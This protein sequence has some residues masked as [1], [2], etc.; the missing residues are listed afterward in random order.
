MFK[1]EDFEDYPILIPKIIKINK[2]IDKD[3]TGN[4]PKI[5]G[6]LGNL[7]E[8]QDLVVQI[9]YILSVIA[10]YDIDLITER[11]IQ[12]IEKFLLSDDDKLKINSIIIIGFYITSNPN[13][14]EK[15]YETF[16]NFIVDN[17]NDVRDNAH[18][19]LQEFIKEKPKLISRYS[20]IILQALEIEEKNK[21]N[22][23]SLLNFLNQCDSLNF[24]QLFK[25]RELSKR[26]ISYFYEGQKSQI[27]QNLIIILNKFFT[28]LKDLKLENL[29]ARELKKLLD[30]QF[31]MKKEAFTELKDRE[32]N[33]TLKDYIEK[34]RNSRLKGV[35][36][37][38]FINDKKNNE[39]YFYQLEKDK[40]I[41]VFDRNKKIPLN[42][43]KILFSEIINS[44][45]ELKSF[46][47]MLVRLGIV[48][49]YLSEFYFYPYNY[50]YTEIMDSF[51]KSGVVNLKGKFDILPPKYVH[52]IILETNQEIL[53]GRN[54]DI[55][56]SLKKI[57][58]E[59]IERAAKDATINLKPYREKLR[60]Y[61]FIKLIKNLPKEYL[62]N[63]R[64]GT[65]FLTN[66]GKNQV[67]TEIN[68]SKLIGFMD[69]NKLS[70]K[71]KINK[72]L[73]MDVI[74]LNIDDRSGI[75]DK[76]KEIFYYSKYIT[77]RIDKINLI[78]DE[79][80]KENQISFISKELNIDRNHILT[81]IDENFKLIGEE[82]KKQD[83]IKINEYLEKTGMEYNLF[84]KFIND[85]QINFFR[86]GDVLILNPN[87]IEE[88]KSSIKRN[89]IDNSKSENFISLG[90][91]DINSSVIENLIYELK[92]EK[93]LKGIF[94]MENEELLFFTEK[95]IRNL[96]LENSFLFSFDDLFYEKELSQEE[97][98]LLTE[99]FNG[100]V[101]ERKLVGNFNQETLTFSSKDVIFASD[102]NSSLFEFEKSVNSYLQK[103]N[104]EFQ[105]I[106]KILTK[107][108][109]TIFPQ[110]IKMIQDTIDR[111]NGKYIFWRE[112]LEAFI[113]RANTTFLKQQGLTVKRYKKL[114]Q[115]TFEVTEKDDIKSFEDDLEVSGLMI[116]FN[117]W[118]KLFNVL[119]LKY[120]NVI[121]YQ[122]RLIANPED[123]ES[124]KKFNDL[125]IILNLKS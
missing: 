90:N 21:E 29:S 23:A 50:I 81:K 97:V 42:D 12:K 93:K 107:Q 34:F 15:F 62:T 57:K 4:I 68:N 104:L 103:F 5:I 67:E 33:I 78:S 60:D 37:N 36:L 105:K 123:K 35:E 84:I 100:L 2:L 14:I 9:T 108:N 112:S 18:Y 58:E 39:T 61:D 66:I 87:K 25:F 19:F 99:I 80:E 89:L 72:I 73:L 76:D 59:I 3:K 31:L 101:K 98:D 92:K 32:K 91:F 124:N 22:I 53:V 71:L 28:S 74:M 24:N 27:K 46:T 13:F 86:K 20:N 56:F 64:K 125:L 77:A 26:L 94:Y 122:K 6:E 16:I 83:K 7:L 111:I 70:E 47:K 119:E 102:Y 52:D 115:E 40:L 109:E 116:E 38:F 117:N 121:F 88:A 96:M 110:E 63:F 8:D 10:E 1:V 69:L 118:V 48:K 41:N 120:P 114:K 55:Y 95:G 79:K 85:L 17:S 75:W 30:D 44:D 43:L 54:N 45:Y 106:K 49:G 82:I 65:I 11:L 51:Q 113:I